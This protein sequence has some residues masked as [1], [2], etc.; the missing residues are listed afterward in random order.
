MKVTNRI[1]DKLDLK[2]VS[3]RGYKQ[4]TKVWLSTWKNGIAIYKYDSIQIKVY[5]CAS[6]DM[7]INKGV[8]NDSGSSQSRGISRDF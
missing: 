3:K 7:N 5:V 1:C 8:K 2:S 4:D 6:L